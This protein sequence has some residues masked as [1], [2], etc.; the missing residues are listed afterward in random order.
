MPLRISRAAGLMIE[1][2]GERVTMT[3][4]LGLKPIIRSVANFPKPGIMF[5]DI[6]PLL[7][8]PQAFQSV[9]DRFADEFRHERPTAI[10]AAES[11]GFI[12]AAPL[13]LQLGAAFIPVR[14]PGK[15]PFQTR[16][17][18]YDLEYGSDTLEMHVDAIEPGQRV[19]L[20]DDL[21]ATGGTIQACAQ[22]AQQSGAEIV[23]FAF[24]IELSF[25]K[26]RDRLAP[27]RVVSLVDYADET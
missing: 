16:S 4:P 23:G 9:V 19:L 22:L 14:K 5:R 26:G 11:R 18:Q 15:L 25:L 10:L 24:L 20:V 12:F 21:L 3:D 8:Q 2:E 27:H 13:A 1:N 7:S 17:L 6:T